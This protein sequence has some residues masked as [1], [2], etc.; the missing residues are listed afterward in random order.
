MWIICVHEE[1]DLADAAFGVLEIEVGGSRSSS[2][3][4][5]HRGRSSR[6]CHAIAART[7]A[8]VIARQSLG[9]QHLTGFSRA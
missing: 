7:T 4:I 6:S 1:L 3:L 9:D 2:R 8:D 5:D